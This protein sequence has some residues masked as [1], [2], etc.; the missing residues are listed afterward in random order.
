VDPK[1]NQAR[2]PSFWWVVAGL[3]AALL[4]IGAL[5][6]A[7]AVQRDATKPIGEGEVFVEDVAAGRTILASTE[8]PEAGVRM[9]RNT[10]DL[11]GVSLLDSDGTVLASTSPNKLGHRIENKLLT[12]AAGTGRFAAIAT[13]VTE[14][15]LLDGVETWASGS[16]LYQVA[17]PAAQEGQ[18]LL[19]YYD[20]ADLLGRR[21]QPGE[22]QP[23]TVQLT[24][25]AAA[26]LL[27][28]GV[29]FLGRTR[30]ASRFEA[31]ELEAGLLRRH[32]EELEGANAEL[33]LARRKA[34]Q[35]LALAE[36][37]IRIRSEFVLMI[38]HE[39]RT[40]LTSVVTGA[41]LLQSAEV[42]DIEKAILLDSIVED[43]RRL[44]EIID[45]IL[46]VARL[47]NRGVGADTDLTTTSE[48]ANSLEATE[49]DEQELR[50]LL[51]PADVGT[52]KL[53]VDFLVDNAQTHGAADASLHVT[54][55]SRIDPQVQVGTVPA[56][57]IYVSVS[58][59]G[60]G[61]DLDFLPR[62]FEKFEKSSIMSGTGLGLYMARVIVEAM[63]GSIGVETSESGTTFEVALPAVA[64]RKPEQVAV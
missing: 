63:Q 11:E 36:E 16:V 1:K 38:N 5:I 19:L 35:A 15:V 30:A 17:A 20:I 13:A 8:D 50:G 45:R 53:I 32:S 29:I 21:A 14:P 42:G 48:L 7:V 44:L 28:G 3:S 41:Q 60:P 55:A 22:L 56:P 37:K 62:V 39:L 34:E 24:A 58:D 61:I 46:A 49:W 18:S 51:I 10:L 43:G 9:I 25:A 40:P 4:S 54:A 6:A 31:M 47:E 27:V 57:A 23:A 12:D 52:V 33:D 26:L 59:D 64:S 2:R